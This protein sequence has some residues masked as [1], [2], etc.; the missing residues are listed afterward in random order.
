METTTSK[1]ARK[2]NKKWNNDVTVRKSEVYIPPRA[3]VRV[4]DH[5][6]NFNLS[7]LRLLH[8]VRSWRVWRVQYSFAHPLP[9]KATE[10]ESFLQMCQSSWTHR[11][12]L[13]R[14]FPA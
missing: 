14:L 7:I 11:Q 2:G 6:R 13:F 8:S 12:S 9:I 10:K 1:C 5:R 3:I 4:R